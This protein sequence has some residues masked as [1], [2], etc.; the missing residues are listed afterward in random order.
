MDENQG[1]CD[2]TDETIMDQC[3]HCGR[4]FGIKSVS[5][6]NDNSYFS[7]KVDEAV[8]EAFFKVHPD[9]LDWMAGMYLER[10]HDQLVHANDEVDRM[11]S[12]HMVPDENLEDF[13]RRTE[14]LILK[15]DVEPTSQVEG[16]TAGRWDSDKEE[17]ATERARSDAVSSDYGLTAGRWD[18]LKKRWF[19]QINTLVNP[20]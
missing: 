9:A 7:I 14:E 5:K 15:A 16:L 4:C 19:T 12:S 2:C 6:S 11:I 20:G 1:K 10:L 8:R 18:P 13:I 3:G 17:W